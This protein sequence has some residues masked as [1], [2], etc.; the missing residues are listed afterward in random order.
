[1]NTLNCL[2]FVVRCALITL[3]LCTGVR[4]GFDADG[5]ADVDLADLASF[6]SCIA[7]P[8]QPLGPCVCIVFDVDCDGDVDLAD[9]AAMQTVFTGVRSQE[10]IE[11]DPP[12]VCVVSEERVPFTV[13]HVTAKGTRTPIDPADLIVTLGGASGEVVS[14]DGKPVARLYTAGD[15]QECG[16][17]EISYTNLMAH[18]P[19][20]LSGLDQADEVAVDNANDD[21]HDRLKDYQH[22]R[23]QLQNA[24]DAFVSEHTKLE[25]GQ[26]SSMTRLEIFVF[27][28]SSA[29][30]SAGVTPLTCFQI[31][32][33][34]G[35]LPTPI[36][37]DEG[38]YRISKDGVHANFALESSNQ[39]LLGNGSLGTCPI[40]NADLT[41]PGGC[42]RLYYDLQIELGKLAEDDVSDALVQLHNNV[43]PGNIAALSASFIDGGAAGVIYLLNPPGECVNVIHTSGTPVS[44][45]GACGSPPTGVQT[46]GVGSSQVIWG[47]QGYTQ[48]RENYIMQS[49]NKIEVT[50]STAQ[51]AA[52]SDAES[53]AMQAL[54]SLAKAELQM[55]LRKQQALA[56]LT[57]IADTHTGSRVSTDHVQEF[58]DQ[59]IDS[60]AESGQSFLTGELMDRIQNGLGLPLEEVSEAF[61]ALAEKWETMQNVAGVIDLLSQIDKPMS[62]T[63]RIRKV[64]QAFDLA[65]A[66]VPGGPMI[67]AIAPFLDFYSTALGAIADALDVID[68]M[69]KEQVLSTGECSIIEAIIADPQR[70]AAWQRACKIR[71]LLETIRDP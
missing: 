50:I 1:M 69:R 57:L 29:A 56:E 58:L 9:F 12:F 62:D 51:Y 31:R 30:L 7:G 8:Q 26:A 59:Y 15:V 39:V 66:F 32:R 49:V 27:P 2:R 34:L 48:P 14:E 20:V 47:Y 35:P 43:G 5:N 6:A 53:V 61:S 41:N 40:L 13:F 3:A 44:H 46:I 68:E 22:A 65:R 4:A 17:L 36:G 24:R 21:L 42:S 55:A 38:F 18:A 33:P 54:A 70:R 16:T 19:L 25:N 28:T 37:C 71:K 45:G 63:D 10:H 23:T 67:T 64:K 52:L 60:L 11:I